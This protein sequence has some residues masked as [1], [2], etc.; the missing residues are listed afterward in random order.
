MADRVGEHPEAGLPLGREP[1]GAEL[2]HRAL[3]RVHVVDPDVEVQ[4]LRALGVR[5]ARRHPGRRALERELA[6]PGS[7]PMTTQSSLSWVTRIPSTAA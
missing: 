3:G 5:P 7:R 2:Q 6:A 1:A 4:L